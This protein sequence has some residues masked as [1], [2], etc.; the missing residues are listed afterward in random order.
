MGAGMFSYAER[1]ARLTVGWE[2]GIREEKVLAGGKMGDTSL[3]TFNN[4]DQA[5]LK[6]TKF[7]PIFPTLSAK[8]Q[9]D[10]EVMAALVGDAVGVQ[11]PAVLRLDDT[12]IVKEF[13][14][15]VMGDEYFDNPKVLA[16]LL[17][18]NPVEA[19]RLGLFT[20][21]I[22][23][24]DQHP[25]NLV[26]Q[27]NRGRRMFRPIDFGNAF[28]GISRVDG[29]LVPLET[30]QT[31]E[32]TDPFTLTG[33]TSLTGRLERAFT[34]DGLTVEQMEEVT[35]RLLALKGDFAAMRQDIKHRLLVERAKMMLADAKSKARRVARD[36]A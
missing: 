6:R 7:N 12:T 18:E 29:E 23:N 24:G 8:D 22:Q 30:Y 3:V 4:G 2:S 5:I 31:D 25:G 36:A 32:I 1:L 14:P 15:G 19:Q 35:T 11:A 20:V 28:M 26:V 33:R 34:S 13:V 10:H 9:A 27:Q 21:L 16:E 17:A